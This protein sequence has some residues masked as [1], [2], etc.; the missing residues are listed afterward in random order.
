MI[1]SVLLF[2]FSHSICSTRTN[3]L[4]YLMASRF[5]Q[6]GSAAVITTTTFAIITAVFEKDQMKYYGYSEAA[7]VAGNALGPV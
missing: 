6:G 3:M 1:I 7:K 5:L 2:A 4:I